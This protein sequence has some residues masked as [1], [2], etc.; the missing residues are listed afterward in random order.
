MRRKRT[1]EVPLG[2]LVV[3][4]EHPIWVEAMGRTHPGEWKRCLE[5][6]E[7]AASSGCEIFRVAVFDEKAVEGLKVIKG[8]KRGIP[9]VAD[10]HFDLSFALSAI[11]AGVDAV[12]INP[13][14]A[15]NKSVVKSLINLARERNVVLRLGA[16]T[17]SLPSYLKGEKRSDALF[18]SVGEYVELA[19]AQGMENLILSAKSTEVEETVEVYRRLSEA[20]PYPLHIGLTEA[21]G[22]IQGIVKSAVAIGI[23]LFEGIGDTLRVSLTSRSPV[24]EAEVAWKILESLGIRSK[25][26]T[27]ISCPTCARRRGD[28][29][30]FVQRFRQKMAGFKV[31]E[32]VAIKVAI[33][34][35]EVN[36]PGEAKEADFGL[37][38][39][40]DGKAV[41]F[42]RGSVLEVVSQEE[43]VEKLLTMVKEALSKEERE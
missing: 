20:F 1:R 38:L 29:V 40:K 13:G 7:K 14:T 9:L 10:I 22:G 36:G 28:V 37:A 34:G 2:S 17:G 4:G 15:K 11:K 32:G 43:G 3:G 19:R 24:L 23:L 5:E 6:M 12:R 33:M 35:C 25:D 16:N 27:L 42:A 21:G 30:S 26:V 41:L 31:P 8:Q 18:E 39:S